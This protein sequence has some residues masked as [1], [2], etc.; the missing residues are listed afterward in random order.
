MR[1]PAMGALLLAVFVFASVVSAAQPGSANLKVTKTDSPDPVRVGSN[2]TYTIGVENL[3]P[4]PATG[5]TVTDNLPRGVDL[6]SATGPAGNC[7]VQGEKVTCAIGSLNPVGVNYGGAPATVT[8]VVVPRRAGTIR[9]TATVKGDQ[10]DPANGNN[11]ATASTRVLA[12]P[13]C[14]GVAANVSGTA[15]DDVLLGTPGPDVIVA[16]GGADRIVSRSGRD[17]ICAGGGAD[18]VAAGSAADLVFAGA[19][20]DRLLGRGGPDLLKGSVGNDVLKGNRG[21]DRLRGG[22]GF[23]RCRGGAGLD[24]TRGCER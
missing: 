19:G 8:I 14:R 11:R 2:L 12:A 17:L 7:A 9:N 6:V 15:G 22:R 1:W 24:S 3:G 23:D 16:F 5:V 13:R 21:A 20:P 18:Y 10:K 4:N